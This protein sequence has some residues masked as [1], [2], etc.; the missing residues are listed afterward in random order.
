MDFSYY[1]NVSTTTQS[2][3]GSTTALSLLEPRGLT[4][5]ADVSLLGLWLAV[6]YAVVWLVVRFFHD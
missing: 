1:C 4:I 6:A 3:V 5:L 2:C